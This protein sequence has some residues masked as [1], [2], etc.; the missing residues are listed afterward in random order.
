MLFGT[1]KNP[2]WLGWDMLNLSMNFPSYYL[3]NYTKILTT[4]WLSSS[5]AGTKQ[6]VTRQPLPKTT[7]W[8]RINGL[9]L[10]HSVTSSTLLILYRA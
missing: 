4:M 9:L 6:K 1:K 3:N 8:I 5:V 7:V 2:L 10:M